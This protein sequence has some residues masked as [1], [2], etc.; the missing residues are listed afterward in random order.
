[1]VA[2]LLV[3]TLASQASARPRD[4]DGSSS[5]PA[6]LEAAAVEALADSAF[7][8]HVGTNIASACVA[9]F[10]KDRVVF[11]K[12]YGL[13]R[14]AKEVSADPEVTAYNAGSCSKLF[15]A[16]AALQLREQGKIRLDEDVNRYLKRFQLEATYPRPVTMADLLTHTGGIEDR[17]LGRS[18]PASDPGVMTL[19][20]YFLRFPPRRVRPAGEQEVLGLRD[21]P[22]GVRGRGSVGHDV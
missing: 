20:E 13:A 19:S 17:T 9:V 1:L 4:G 16:T 3:A 22:G 8:P 11:Q 10:R 15:V 6:A 2:L 18:S 7:T 12:G 5:D 21:G 14:P